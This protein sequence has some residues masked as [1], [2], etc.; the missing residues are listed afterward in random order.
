[1][2]QPVTVRVGTLVDVLDDGTLKVSFARALAVEAVPV[3]QIPPLFSQVVCLSTYDRVYV[4]GADVRT[5]TPEP[6]PEPRA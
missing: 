4:L 6:E 5:A 3:G 1:M 2:T